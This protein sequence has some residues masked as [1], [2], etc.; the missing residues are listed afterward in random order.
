MLPVYTKPVMKSPNR[1]PVGINPRGK[2]LGGN[3]ATRKIPKEI[4]RKIKVEF[5]KKE[6]DKLKEKYGDK[7]LPQNKIPNILYKAK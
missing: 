7:G 6:L 4:D 5:S 2:P 3:G 1:L